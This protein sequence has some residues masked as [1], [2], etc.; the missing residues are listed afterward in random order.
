MGMKLTEA[1]AKDESKVFSEKKKTKGSTTDSGKKRLLKKLE[2]VLETP[3]DPPITKPLPKK[4]RHRVYTPERKEPIDK[5][6]RELLKIY[7]KSSVQS[8]KTVPPKT[9]TPTEET[10]KDP[11]EAWKPVKAQSEIQLKASRTTNRNKAPKEKTSPKKTLSWQIESH[12]YSDERDIVIGFD[13]G[14]ACSKVILQDHQ[15]KKAFAVPFNEISYEPNRYLLHTKLF[16]DPEGRLSLYPK[17]TEVSDLKMDFIDDPEKVTFEEKTQGEKATAFDLMAAYIGLTLKEVR[18]WFRKK[19]TLEYSSSLITWELNL[20]IPARDYENEKLVKA[21]KTAALTGWNLTLPLFEEIRLGNVRMAR[22]IAE[23]L[24]NE[25]ARS[26]GT[27][28]I[29]PDN[30]SVI[31]EIIAEVI[32]YSR[33]PMRQ[34]GMYLLVDIGASTLDVSTFI[35]TEEDNEDSYPILFADIEKLGGYELHKYRISTII[36]IIEKKL[37]TLSAACDGISPL[38]EQKEY[39]S[40]LT[41]TDRAAF[42]NSDRSFCN[43]CSLVMRRVVGM[44]KKKRNPNSDAWRNGLPVFLCGGGSLIPL[45]KDAVKGAFNALE[46]FGVQ[47]FNFVPLPKPENIETEDIPPAD[48]HRVAVSYGLSFSEFDIGKIIPQKEL[49]DIEEIKTVMDIRDLYIDK[50]KM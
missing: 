19:K 36:N 42:S 38:P 14:T 47:G 7:P 13:L 24:I 49:D 15:L 50:D 21:M 46:T 44:T 43:G 8:K 29:H 4:T 34:N 26:L 45:Y 27:E 12:T 25:P 20:G 31:P 41:S 6:Q 18:R 30:I 9:K 5:Q 37:C 17:G 48:Y 1:L 39:F 11:A 22:E 40:E 32:G 28:Q 10:K 3:K 23:D 35:L 16:V 33:S 2:P